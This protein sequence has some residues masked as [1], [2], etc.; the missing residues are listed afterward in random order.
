MNVDDD[1]DY[2]F[3]VV[4]IGDSG[5]GKSSLLRRFSGRQFEH[6]TKATIGV[7][8]SIHNMEVDGK[9]IRTQVWDTAGQE[10]YRAIANMYY[11]KATGVIL[12]YDITNHTSFK[13]LSRW[14]SEARSNAEPEACASIVGNKSDLRHL[15]TVTRTEAEEFA[16]NNHVGFLETSA[17]D[18]SNVEYV[19]EAII[20]DMYE[21][22]LRQEERLSS[23]NL[24]DFMSVQPKPESRSCCSQL[25]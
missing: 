24:K 2:L 16:K 8:F 6:E 12:V 19:F 21:T 7:E 20:T 9:K 4:L 3:K 15:R 25:N 23:Y 17:M 1:C 22:T 5:V 14:L 13:S 18:T 11:R 10:R